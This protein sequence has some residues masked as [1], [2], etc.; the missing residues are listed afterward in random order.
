MK[1]VLIIA[2]LTTLFISALVYGSPKLNKIHK[3]MD[4]DGVKINCA[5]CHKKAAIVKGGKNY[6]QHQKGK[7]CAGS[8][9]H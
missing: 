7:F 5:Y 8:G 4:R 2:T 9:C 1:N 3:G 6:K